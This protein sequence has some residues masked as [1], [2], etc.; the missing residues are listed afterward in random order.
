MAASGIEFEISYFDLRELTCE[1]RR[2]V[3]WVLSLAVD[4]LLCVTRRMEKKQW[5]NLQFDFQGPDIDV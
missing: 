3:W 5:A 2:R 4:A 1:W